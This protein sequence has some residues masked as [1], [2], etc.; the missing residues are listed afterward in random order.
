[1]I[2]FKLILSAVYGLCA[3]LVL[4]AS[5]EPAQPVKLS[6]L[7]HLVRGA[8]G[9]NA[10]VVRFTIEPKW[11]LYWSNPGESGVTEVVQVRLPEGWKA[12]PVVFPRPQILGTSQERVYGYESSL[13][14]LVPVQAPSGELPASISVSASISWMAC[15]E[16]CV[17]G[18]RDLTLTIATTVKPTPPS[19]IVR[20]YP[21]KLPD[22]CAVRIENTPLALVITA[23][24]TLLAAACASFIPDANAGIEFLHGIGPFSFT[25]TGEQVTMRAAIAVHPEDAVDGP[26]RVRGLLLTG[27]RESDPA[28]QID[29]AA[30]DVPVSAQKK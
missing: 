3:A 12:H 13:D 11:H 20:A 2:C 23:P 25:Q 9:G 27:A 22:S 18:K 19:A 14:L 21:T 30:P 26:A 7:P 8:D 24:A 5:D 16:A 4:C 28:Y 15:K 17:M 6:I 1:M 10:L 29:L